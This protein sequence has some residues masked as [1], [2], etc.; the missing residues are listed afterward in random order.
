M[1]ILGRYRGAIPEASTE[2]IVEMQIRVV[3]EARAARAADRPLLQMLWC[4]DIDAERDAA[5][6][7]LVSGLETAEDDIGSIEIVRGP[8]GRFKEAL[9]DILSRRTAEADPSPQTRSKTSS[10][11]TGTT[12]PIRSCCR[13]APG[14]SS[15]ATPR[16]SRSTKAT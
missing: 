3:R 4:P 14:C 10:S 8:L 6:E 2:S 9:L 11:A 15:R 16:T 5:L 7:T 12:S 13:S 1:H